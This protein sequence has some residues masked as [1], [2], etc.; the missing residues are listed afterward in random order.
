MTASRS[1]S[2]ATAFSRT[3]ATVVCARLPVHCNPS[4][5]AQVMLTTTITSSVM[6]KISPRSHRSR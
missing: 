5:A 3:P 2:T 4:N 1:E 6:I